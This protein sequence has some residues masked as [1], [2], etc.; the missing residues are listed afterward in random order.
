MDSKIKLPQIIITAF[1]AGLFVLAALLGMDIPELISGSRSEERR[2]G[3]EC[4]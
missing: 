4:R 1:M 3:K 2:V